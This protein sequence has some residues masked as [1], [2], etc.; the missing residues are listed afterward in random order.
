MICSKS[1]NTNRHPQVVVLSSTLRRG[2]TSCAPPINCSWQDCGEKSALRVTCKRR[3]AAGMPIICG[4]TT[5]RCVTCYRGCE[6]VIGSDLMPAEAVVATLRSAWN[7]LADL[8][9][10][11]ALMGGLALAHWD[12]I[13]S[14]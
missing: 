12:H 6:E 2:W 3:T 4:S 1:F 5:T 9:V 11:A 8:Q 10:P 7:I 14:T 13:R